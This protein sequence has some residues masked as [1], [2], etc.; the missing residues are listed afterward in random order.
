MITIL[1]NNVKC[2]IEN[3]LNPVIVEKIREQLSYLVKGYEF[4][5]TYKIKN[6]NGLRIW[7]GRKHLFSLKT[8]I[9]PSGC[10]KRVEE[11][12]NSF[13]VQYQINDL[14]PYN[15]LI[16]PIQIQNI[17]PYNYQEDVMDKVI[18]AE[19][20]IAEVATGGGKSLII[21]MVTGALNL[22]TLIIVHTK[23]LLYQMKDNIENYLGI[24]CGIIGDSF[25]ELERITVGM[26]Q[27]SV[28]A[29]NAKYVRYDDQEISYDIILDRE[30]KE[31][32]KDFITSCNVVIYDECQHLSCNTFQDISKY[33]TKARYR[34]G[35]SATPRRDDNSDILIE[36]ATG[37]KAV[38]YNAS[39]LID[40]GFLVPPTIYYYRIP[41][42]K[43]IK[44][45]YKTRYLKFIVENEVRNDIIVKAT[46]KFYN[47]NF[48]TVILVNQKKHGRILIDKLKMIGINA[49]FL[50]GDI[51]SSAERQ[52]ILKD[53]NDSD[54]NVLIG[55]SLLDEGVNLPNLKCIILAG[56]GMSSTR[57][58]QRV[59]RAIRLAGEDKK[60]A[61]I[62]DFI[63]NCKYMKRHSMQR[64]EI[65]KEEPRFT[66][67]IQQGDFI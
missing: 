49:A 58:L 52:K 8:Q 12:L 34:M 26:A 48:K 55:T 39:Y 67:K 23:D 40:R 22:Q 45:T 33:T 61:W 53:F 38:K 4:C 60:K 54:L 6:D 57:A 47:K 30:K 14:R 51:R 5:D 1:R 17:T 42:I 29:L 44:G 65:F 43:G 41:P 25:V 18:K 36:A 62:I 64:M 59:G 9:F 56:S 2:K 16:P 31:K 24:K 3:E 7:D 10:L 32:I 63:D 21:S 46:Q 37:F 66:I 35:F 20:A 13:G 27:S 19:C 28:I 11:V 50:Q 15:E